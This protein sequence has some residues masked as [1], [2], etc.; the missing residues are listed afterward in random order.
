MEVLEKQLLNDSI[1]NAYIFECNNSSYNL[2]IANSFSKKIFEKNGLFIE[3]DIN[4]DFILIDKDDAV[5]SIAD[6][7]ELVRDIYKKPVMGNVKVFVINHSENLRKESANAFLKSLEEL[8]EYVIIIF[9]TK[10]SHALLKTIRSRCQILTFYKDGEESP[11]DEEALEEV[12]FQ[13]LNGNLNFY[14]EKKDFFVEYKNYKDDILN[15]FLNFYMKLLRF[16]N[17]LNENENLSQKE[18]FYFKKLND[19][20][21]DKIEELVKKVLEIKKAYKNNINYDLSIEN[22]IFYTYRKAR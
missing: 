15:S 8:K 20:S 16:K 2:E 1:A 7:R 22:L 17:N 6:I 3:N 18:I 12:I 13:I 14:Y 10:N 5:I 21:F 9:L 19:L 11:L 4:P